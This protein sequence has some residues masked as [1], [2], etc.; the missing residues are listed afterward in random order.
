MK[1]KINDYRIWWDEVHFRDPDLPTHSPHLR[2]GPIVER[3]VSHA[4]FLVS[5][6]WSEERWIMSGKRRER[7]HV[8][9]RR[10][11]S[12][13]NGFAPLLRYAYSVRRANPA[14]CAR[15]LYDYNVY[16]PFFS[17]CSL[18]AS[19]TVMIIEERDDSL[20]SYRL[21]L[22]TVSAPSCRYEWGDE[23]AEWVGKG[24]TEI[25]SYKRRRPRFARFLRF[26]YRGRNGVVW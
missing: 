14:R 4:I 5:T 21:F 11:N 20:P 24:N 10:L 12:F 8:M 17:G 7:W 23:G 9:T 18:P 16:K 1:C 22:V 26:L 13:H 25:I 19:L 2:F 6:M 15:F 3:S